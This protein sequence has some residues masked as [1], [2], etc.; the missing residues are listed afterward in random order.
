MRWTAYAG[1][2]GVGMGLL[3]VMVLF[4]LLLM[5]V[6]ACLLCLLVLM[7]RSGD[8]RQYPLLDSEML[9]FSCYCLHK[10]YELVAQ[11]QDLRV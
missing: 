4:L 3:D 2:G 9:L 8:E 11:S 10:Q 5:L 6:L 7:Y 1:I